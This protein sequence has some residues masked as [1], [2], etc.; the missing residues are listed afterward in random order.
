MRILKKS[1]ESEMIAIF[2][3]EEINSIRFNKKIIKLLKKMNINER[4]VINYD[5]T[6]DEENKMRK[7]LLSQ[8]RGYE[9]DKDIF[10]NFPINIDWYW[11]ELSVEDIFKIKYITYDYWIELSNGSRFAKDCVNN[12]K[13]NIEVFGVSNTGFIEAAEYI[14]NGNKFDPI[15]LVAPVE[16]KGN[17]IVLEGHLR[18]TAMNLVIENIDSITA[19]IGYAEEKELNKWDNY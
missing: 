12:I 18:L 3:K 4:V 9:L 15:I 16:N 14:S 5:L 6:N 11:I 10:K 1:S 8:Y 17:M 2:L 13:N 7:R 19:L